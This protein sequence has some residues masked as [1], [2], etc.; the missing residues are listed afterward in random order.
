MSIYLNDDKNNCCG[1]GACVNICPR[2]AVFMKKDEYGFAYPV[3]DPE[4]CVTC[5][6]CTDVCEKVNKNE[7][8]MPLKAFAASHRNM[9]VLRKSTS[10]G[11]FSALAEHII[12]NG[13][14]VF[15]CIFDDD[16][17][18]VHVCTEKESDYLKVRKSK[19][20]QSDVGLIYRDVKKRVK[21]GQLVLFTGSPCNLGCLYWLV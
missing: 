10:G 20:L 7:S 17:R 12:R 13:G 4:K 19:Y 15:G 3:I 5:G 1:C 11:V 21:Q 6:L 18:A 2:D 16:M 14:A 8:D 9:D